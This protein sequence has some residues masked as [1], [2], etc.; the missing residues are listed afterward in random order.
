MSPP[1]IKS[2]QR[3]EGTKLRN[4][5]R[6]NLEL[7][8]SLLFPNSTGLKPFG[9][10]QRDS[11]A[12]DYQVILRGGRVFKAELRGY[13]TTIRTG[14]AALEGVC[15]GCRRMIPVFSAN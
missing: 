8:N 13:G 15:Y 5:C 11:I 3:G 6:R 9:S 7:F 12:H 14:N 1:P 4:K 2:K 10:I